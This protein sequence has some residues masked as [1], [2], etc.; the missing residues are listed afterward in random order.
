MAVS[1]LK[2]GQELER[3]LA[4]GKSLAKADEVARKRW[5]TKQIKKRTSLLK[6]V[7]RKLKE[8]F[9]GEKMYAGKKFPSTRR[10]R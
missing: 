8:V 6:K 9:Y 5:K 10:K 1:R 4:G 2:Y 3:Q 7:S